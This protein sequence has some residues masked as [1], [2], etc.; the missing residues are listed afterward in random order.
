MGWPS[1]LDGNDERGLLGAS[2]VADMTHVLS[3]VHWGHLRDPEAGAHNL[4]GQRA[5]NGNSASV[6]LG[7]VNA[8]F[9]WSPFPT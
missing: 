1:A 3:G 7:A 2:T 4:E 6:S 5:V 8:T 9:W